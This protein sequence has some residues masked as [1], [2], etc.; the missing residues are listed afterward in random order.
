MGQRVG[1]KVMSGHVN[2]E[3]VL[4]L[5]S[6]LSQLLSSLC[7]KTPIDKPEFSS[8]VKTPV[9]S[10]SVA[11]NIFEY[12]TNIRIIEDRIMIFVFGPF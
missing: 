7:P 3:W 2:G 11:T 10:T 1:K 4:S 8:K 6:H 9:P 5:R 12:I